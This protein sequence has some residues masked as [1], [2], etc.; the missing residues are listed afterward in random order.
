MHLGQCSYGSNGV[1][2]SSTPRGVPST[3]GHTRRIRRRSQRDAP[4]LNAEHLNAERGTRN[5][6]RGTGFNHPGAARR[7]KISSPNVD[8]RP[9]ALTGRAAKLPDLPGEGTGP[10]DESPSRT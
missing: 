9:G 1:N 3:L 6:E 10:T 7:D 5:A 2:G 4:Y 8:C